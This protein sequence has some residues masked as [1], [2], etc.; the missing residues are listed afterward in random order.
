MQAIFIN[1]DGYRYPVNFKRWQKKTEIHRAVY[2][3]IPF[4]DSVNP[5]SFEQSNYVRTAYSLFLLIQPILFI[6]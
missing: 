3:N 5:F 4:Q 1:N 6:F 2:K